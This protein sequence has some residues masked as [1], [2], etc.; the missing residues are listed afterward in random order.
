MTAA[1]SVQ[2]PEASAH[3]PS[4]GIASTL[5]AVLLTVR[6]DII[7]VADERLAQREPMMTSK[8][9]LQKIV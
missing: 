4:P 6:V 2:L 9:M 8:T 1:R 7:A 3:T 5:S